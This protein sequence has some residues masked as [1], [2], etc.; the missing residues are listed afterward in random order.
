MIVGF[1]SFIAIVIVLA[2]FDQQQLPNWPLKISLNTFLAFLT[3][4]AKAAFMFPVSVAIS[5]ISW[6]WSH[7]VDQFTTFTS[8][9]K[10]GP[11]GSAQ[12]V[13]RMRH[14]HFITLGA[15]LSIVSVITSLIPQLAISYPL[16]TVVGTEEALVS[17]LQSLNHLTDDPG[18]ATSNAV[19]E[20]S[21]RC[22]YRTEDFA[23]QEIAP[24]VF[25][26]LLLS[27]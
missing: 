21:K 26:L 17:A 12:L 13:F 20:A 24:L 7:T 3:I 25:T 23:R 22:Q 10:Q 2:T 18:H 1:A 8:L 4:V 16:R 11:L 6:S 5:Q 9:T 19:V 27:V 14:K 15:L